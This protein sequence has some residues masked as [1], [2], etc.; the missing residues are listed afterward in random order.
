SSLR[1]STG[2]GVATDGWCTLAWRRCRCGYTSSWPIVRVGWKAGLPRCGRTLTASAATERRR[3][4]PGRPWL[5]HARAEPATPLFREA[6]SRAELVAGEVLYKRRVRRELTLAAR[7][8]G[9]RSSEIRM[10][11]ASAFRRGLRRPRWPR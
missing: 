9:L 1:R 5:A 3:F 6:V 7:R 11:L 2:A 4:P 10:T 8:V